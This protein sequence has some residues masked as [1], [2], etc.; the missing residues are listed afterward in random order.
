MIQSD[1]IIQVIRS[2]I[3]LAYPLKLEVKISDIAFP[4]DNR[5][6]TKEQEKI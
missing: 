6:K 5:I 2:N 1:R 3:I 4:D